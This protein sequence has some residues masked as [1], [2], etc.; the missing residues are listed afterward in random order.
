MNGTGRRNTSGERRCPRER[1]QRERRIVRR[2]PPVG[3]GWKMAERR[4]A[5]RRHDT[6]RLCDLILEGGAG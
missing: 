3:V 1:R 2:S 4:L 5:A 6:R